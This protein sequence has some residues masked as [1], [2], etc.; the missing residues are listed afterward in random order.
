MTVIDERSAGARLRL[1]PAE[2]AGALGLPPPTVEQA[3]IIAAPLAP[4]LVVAGAG[5]GKTETM[6]AR[7]VWLVANGL[8]TPDRV[9]G[10]TF[11]RKAAGE[12][13]ERIRV[14]LGMLRS[15]GM[16]P[17]SVAEGSSSV[18]AEP[19]DGDDEPLGEPVVSTYHSY[20]AR[21]VT[22][23]GLRV[24]IEPGAHVLTEARA[25]QLADQVVRTYDGDMT[26]VDKVPATVT[27]YLLEL[28][29]QLAE[30]LITPGQVRAWTTAF[31]ERVSMLPGT[32]YRAVQDVLSVAEHRV[33]LLPLLEAYAA[34]KRAAGAVDF[35]DQVALAAGIASE[36]DVVRRIERE[37]YEVVLLDEYQDTSHSQLTLLRSLFGAGHPVTAVGDPCQSIYGWRG[38][39]AGNLRRFPEHFPVHGSAAGWGDGPVHGSAA[40][41][42]DG[43]VHGSAAGW[44]DGPVQ[45][46][47]TPTRPAPVLP[48]STSWRNDGRLLAVANALAGP[49]REAGLAVPVLVPRRGREHAG[50][51]KV[52]LHA[53]ALDEADWL[54]DEVAAAW[55]AGGSDGRRPT[56][57]VLARNRSDFPRLDAALR[58]RG[59]PVEMV[60]LGGLLERPEV[61]DVIA[62]LA[63]LVDPTAG[64]ALMRLLT[65]PRWRIGPRDL[66]ALSRR[67]TQLVRQRYGTPTAGGSAEPTVEPMPDEVEL[68]SIVD[69]LDDL[70]P[71]AEYSPIGYERL[72]QL[73]AELRQLRTRT[74]EPLPDL[75]ADVERALGLEIELAVHAAGRP[76]LARA[77]LDRLLDVAADFAATAEAPTVSAFLAY[78]RAAEEEERGLDPGETEVRTDAVQILTV[79]AA[80]GLEWDVVAVPGL[81]H[82]SFPATGGSSDRWTATPR[83]LPFQLRGDAADLPD[84]RLDAAADQKEAKAALAEFEA[85]WKARVL[86]EERRL[87][88]VAVTRARGTVLCSGHR[89]P[90]H[91]KKP[92]P[93][94]EFLVEIADVCAGGA[95]QVVTW[96]GE[97]PP[98]AENPLLGEPR[99]ASWPIDPLS[100]Q[101][102]AA[103]TEAATLVDD[104][105]AT[106]LTRAQTATGADWAG[107]ASLLLAERSAGRRDVHD[108]ELPDHVS[109]SQLVALRRDP[110]DLAREIRRPM[111][112]PPAPLARRGTAFHTWLEVR[113]GGDTLLDLDE[114][115]GAADSGAA[116]DDDLA[117]LQAAFLASEWAD[118]QPHQV[119]VPFATTIAGV[120]V[121]GRIDAVFADGA[122]ARSVGGT[123]TVVDWKTGRRPYGAEAAA[124]AVQLA[125][126]RLAWAEL[127]D[128]PVDSVGAAF[129]YVRDGITVRPIDLL[130]AAGLAALVSRSGRTG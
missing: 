61:R 125:V 122:A 98:D 129:H 111:P 84:W 26:G 115:P 83:V 68:R 127:A 23:H 25:W 89:W 101:R 95:G 107:E 9:L 79:H 28:A 90:V 113:F 30:H 92:R 6:A 55:H 66:D 93:V 18:A 27:S 21:I 120:N 106:R 104:M 74:G 40:G 97:P 50:T 108:V 91:T 46:E 5:S 62:T 118:R 53:T 77:H 13:A 119:E 10:L 82:G 32:V 128:V 1:T 43:P 59:L 78:L 8:V 99:A 45:R 80:K 58:A 33:L 57:A 60:G 39:S 65:G 103:L 96:A 109:V 73:Q 48:L 36:I 124:A 3:A 63:V 112:Y 41:W 116:P 7:V 71:P 52:A 16:L 4:A 20:A 70:G 87:A 34:R 130:D 17:S 56:I 67:A 38:A 51:V 121:R 88:Y 42:G 126:Y 31:T 47:T 35:G 2:L 69:A 24:G 15:R 75:V 110:A 11:T 44:G 86:V 100:P 64:S 117:A 81:C 29:G 22:E 114:L 102:R 105:R 72:R 85:D 54:A 76:A 49:L 94:A 123:W 14:R 37:R 19:A 12:L